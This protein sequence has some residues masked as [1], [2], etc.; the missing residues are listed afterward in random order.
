MAVTLL[1]DRTSDHAFGR[2]SFKLRSTMATSQETDELDSPR[3]TVCDR[4]VHAH[5]NLDD[6]QSTL[7]GIEEDLKDVQG[8]HDAE[9]RTALRALERVKEDVEAAKEA[10]EALHEAA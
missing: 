2:L 5:Q 9:L 1:T 6:L 3:V 10:A 4:T 7:W 8:A